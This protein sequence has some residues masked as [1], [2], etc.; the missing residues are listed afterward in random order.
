MGLTKR[1]L[2]DIQCIAIV[3]NQIDSLTNILLK[4]KIDKSND[5]KAKQI[6]DLIQVLTD[7]IAS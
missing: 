1:E 3:Q 2:I 4:L 6:T 7:S 5:D